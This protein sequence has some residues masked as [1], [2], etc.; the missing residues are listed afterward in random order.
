M[1]T[2]T[3]DNLVKAGCVVSVLILSPRILG[4]LAGFESRPV[5]ISEGCFIFDSASLPLEVGW[6]IWSPMCTKVAVKHPIIII[7]IIEQPGK[8]M[9]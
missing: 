3:H 1:N 5:G 7:I 2:R 4:G 9:R 8:I 6:P